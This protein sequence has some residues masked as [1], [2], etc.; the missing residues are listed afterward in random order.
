[1]INSINDFK[2]LSPSIVD[3]K[4]QI[5]IKNV[6]DWEFEYVSLSKNVGYWIAEAPFYDDGFEKYKN[7]V[8]QIPVWKL[9]TEY[10]LEDPNPMATI[11]LPPWSY[12]ELCKL[13]KSFYIKQISNGVNQFNDELLEEWG[14][15]YDSKIVNPLDCWRLPH[16]DYQSGVIGNLWFTDHS[17][18]ETGTV[19]YKYTGKFYGNYY[20]FH[21]DTEH[22]LHKE[23]KEWNKFSR[24]NGW[25]NLTDDELE[26]WGFIKLGMAPTQYGKMTLYETNIPHSVYIEETCKFRW[27][28][29]FS[30][31]HKPYLKNLDIFNL[32]GMLL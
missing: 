1:M 13:M 29:C 21:V 14:N 10:G 32:S 22:P 26:K 25:V 4:N 30:F 24:T 31:S 7:F 15:I 27:S 6:D 2:V 28:H 16:I 19:F 8:H 9:N 12:S 5:K 17:P 18:T 3:F 11:H 23:W 20:D